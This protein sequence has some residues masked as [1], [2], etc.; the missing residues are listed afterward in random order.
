[1]GSSAGEISAEDVREES[2]YERMK[3]LAKEEGRNV[4][5]LLALA[6]KNDPY[7]VGSPAQMRKAEWFASLWESFGFTSGVH[8]RRVHYQLVSQESPVGFDG[9]PYRTKSRR[10]VPTC[11]GCPRARPAKLR[12]QRVTNGSS[13]LGEVTLSSLAS[14]KPTKARR[15]SERRSVRR[16]DDPRAGY[17]D[18][19]YSRALVR[20]GMR[21]SVTTLMLRNRNLS[22]I[23]AQA[24]R[25]GRDLDQTRQVLKRIEAEGEPAL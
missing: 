11:L 15:K 1:M 25:I 3:R 4:P 19:P 20:L 16:Q 18:A 10:C 12:P 7:F 8:V 6:P 14:T 5:D 9:K 2:G 24:T 21:G 23:I 17:R 13:M 22:G